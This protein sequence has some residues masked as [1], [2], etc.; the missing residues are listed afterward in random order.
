MRLSIEVVLDYVFAEPTDMLLAIEAAHLP[1]QQIVEDRLTILGAGPLAVISS[2]DGVGRRTWCTASGAFNARYHAI[3]DVDRV[4]DAIE[5]LA[6]SPRTQLPGDVTSYLLPSRYCE[7]D[8][9][10]GFARSEFGSMAGGDLVVAIVNW[11]R[12]H[13]TYVANVSNGTTSA[14][15]TFLSRQG[16]CRDFGHLTVAL[17]RARGIPARLVSAYAWQMTPP[18]FHAV[19]EVWLD[20]RWRMVDATGLAPISGMVR[21]V[22]GR[23][24][25]DVAFMTTFGFAEL[26]NQHVQ[27]DRVD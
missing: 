22:A 23:D 7:A 17:V 6:V 3:V 4:P 2:G 25:T 12:T 27:I 9:F 18:D 20:G 13:V 14:V 19:V 26:H 24:A 16:V 5:G 11:V 15:D 21:I 10:D 1:D 8:R